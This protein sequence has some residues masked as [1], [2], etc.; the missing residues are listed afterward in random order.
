MDNII[1]MQYVLV[2]LTCVELAASASREILDL[3]SACMN[4]V[5]HKKHILQG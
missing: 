4:C 3:K 5:Y 1:F 2:S